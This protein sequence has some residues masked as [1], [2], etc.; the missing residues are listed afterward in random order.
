M[1]KAE[2]K[3]SDGPSRDSIADDIG[4]DIEALRADVAAI[5]ASLSKYGALSAEEM[6]SRAQGLSD[7]AVAETVRRVK[8]LRQEADKLQ[9]QL[10]GEVRAHPL[11]WLVGALGLGLLFGLMSSRR[12]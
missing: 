10:E 12:K 1:A 3:S 11:L 6:K 8:E 4:K 7:E 9:G 2:D 5:V